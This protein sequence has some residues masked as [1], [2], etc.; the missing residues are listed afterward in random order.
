MKIL[1]ILVTAFLLSNAAQASSLTVQTHTA[2]EAG[3]MVNSHLIMG[4]REAILV[5][6]QF[7]RSEARKVAEM[8]KASKRRLKAIFITHGHPDHYF[9]LEVLAKE[10]PSVPILAAAETINEIKATSAGKL[11]YWKPMY[12]DDLTDT[13]VLPKPLSQPVLTVD[14]Q[15]L[16]L[17]NLTPG[18][19]ESATILFNRE[20]GLLVAGDLAYNQVHLWLAENRPEGWL[21]NLADLKS[22]GAISSVLTG[23]GPVADAS[24]LTLNETYIRDFVTATVKTAS[25]AKAELKTKYPSFKLPIIAEL[26]VDARKG[27]N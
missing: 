22:L 1:N 25:E 7:T 18:E 10:F 19:S 15:R 16:E 3:F 24:V 27:S 12:K 5:D 23:H 2:N 13:I 17:V 14:G 26:S 9:G 8:V 20:Q 6:A 21:K 4:A 11:A